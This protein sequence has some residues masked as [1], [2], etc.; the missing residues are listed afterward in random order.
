MKT[1]RL[2]VWRNK[3]TGKYLTVFGWNF[4]YSNLV[5][6]LIFP[7]QFISEK[8]ALEWAGRENV[9]RVAVEKNPCG[10]PQLKQK[11]KKS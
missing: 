7:N 3:Q 10:F 2:H 5:C 8:N 9:E 1:R 11:Q 4:D 6:A